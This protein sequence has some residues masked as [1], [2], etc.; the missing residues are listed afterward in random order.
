MTAAPGLPAGALGLC[1]LRVD[2]VV[3]SVVKQEAGWNHHGA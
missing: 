3:G 1:V 2:G